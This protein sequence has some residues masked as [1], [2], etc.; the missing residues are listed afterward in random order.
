MKKQNPPTTGKR[1]LCLAIALVMVLGMLP[2]YALSAQADDGDASAPLE[3][4][5]H[6]QNTQNWDPLNLYVWGTQ[7]ANTSDWPGNP[8]TAN[9]NNDGWFDQ[10]M[11][12]DAGGEAGVIP[13]NGSGAQTQDIMLSEAGHYW[14]TINED[15]SASIL[16]YAPQGWVGQEPQVYP[17]TIYAQKPESWNALYAHIWGSVGSDTEW[18]GAAMEANNANADWFQIE[19]RFA[20][21]SEL[22]MVL[23]NNAGTQTADVKITA[24]GSHWITIND[25]DEG[26]KSVNLSQEAPEGWLEEAPVYPEITLHVENSQGWESMNLH[27]WGTQDSNTDWP[28][29]A[30]TADVYNPGWFETTVH[31]LEGATAGFIPNNNGAPQTVNIELSEAG[32]YWVTIGEPAEEGAHHSVQVATE[33]PETWFDANRKFYIP[34]TFPGNSWDPASNEM[35]YDP[36][37]GLY[38]FTFENVPAANYQYKIAVDGSWAE[39][40]GVDGEP[41]GSNYDVAVTE[42][43]DVTIYY[44]DKS[45]RSV[46]SLNYVFADISLVGTGIPEGT[47]L[48][49]NGLTGI[50]S[51]SVKLAAGTYA[52]IQ[53][54]T[55]DAVESFASFELAEDTLVTF[56]IDPITG[57]CYHDGCGQVENTDAIYY[58]SQELAYKAPYGA[59]ANGSD[60]TFH[61]DCGENIQWAKLALTGGDVL[62]MEAVDGGFAVT[63]SFAKIGE[64][65][66]YFVLSDGA[67]V[68]VYGD[69]DGYYG[70]GCVTDLTQVRPFGLV[71]YQDG[72][73]TPDWVKNAVM[74][75]IFPDRFFDGDPSNN[76]AQTWARGTVGY[77]F[78]EDWYTLPENPEM[79]GKDGYPENALAGDGN[80]SNEMYGGDLEGITQRIDYLKALGVNVIYLNPV[81]WSISNHR[82][83]AVDYGTIDPILGDLGDFQELVAVAEA[84]DM[85]IILDGVFN[86]VSDDSIYFD[87]Y[88]RFLGEE[89]GL[90]TVGAYP[91]WAYVYDYMADTGA[92]QATAEAAAKTYFTD[93]YGVTDFSYVEWF[94]V[95]N[96][97]MTD[98]NGNAVC[99]TIGDRAGKPV[100]VYEG[101]WGYDSMPVIKSTNGSE[102]QTGNWAEKIIY[103]E[104]ESS[105]TQ[106]WITEG[107]NGWRLDVANEVSDE[108]WQ[109][110]RDSVKALDS[111]AVIIGEIWDD[112]TKYILGDMYDS[113]M[114]YVFRNNVVRFAM[115]E[116]T[117]TTATLEMEKIRERYPEEA[118]YAMMN[119]V[120]SHDTTRILSFL[121]GIPDDR[122]GATMETAFPTYETTS[123]T[124]KARQYLVSLLQFTYAGAPT[125]YYG[126]ELGMVG[127]D[128]PDDRR[129]MEWGRGQQELVEWYAKLAAIRESYSA[130]RTGSVKPLDLGDDNLLAFIRADEETTIT[131]ITNNAEAAKTV[132]L[133]GSF[134][135]LLT[136]E[137]FDGTVPADNGVILV[138]P[139]DV[140]EIEVNYA[141]LAPAYDPAYDVEGTTESERPFPDVLEHHWFY[142]DVYAMYDAGIILG[143]DEGLFEPLRDVNRAEFAIMLYRTLGLTQTATE[144]IFTD[145]PE[146]A[147][148]YNE[149]TVLAEL[150]II[151]GVGGDAFAPFQPIM[152]QELVTMVYR[153]TEGAEPGEADLTIFTDATRIDE[154][155]LDSMAWAVDNGIIQGYDDGTVQPKGNTIRAEAATIVNRWL[156]L[157][158]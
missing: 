144:P 113:V 38:T 56:Y 67:S 55:E 105:I 35:T 85:H 143:T 126:D 148:F 149:V 9:P 39:N 58:H 114:N 22:G 68:V 17:V 90:D 153:A 117:A 157:L 20:Q 69:D 92:D 50:Y 136:G 112:A 46:T 91:Y 8:M 81:F 152:R 135:D 129:S 29:N 44:S 19:A 146:T 106:Y 82:Y 41:D 89:Y 119:L 140:V 7:D 96:R 21:G 11:H 33:A 54:I 150:G 27:V 66:Y 88:Y 2:G 154:Y 151:N 12:I 83:D 121:D 127:A 102:F 15:N 52:D 74:Y 142:E 3:I 36:E 10:T 79:V 147:W 31:I 40:Y 75:Q 141:D 62:D 71:V 70:Q 49:D 43:T 32:E 87:R 145:V 109:N 16:T 111:E 134:V 28:G 101:W 86:H 77:E 57:I 45:H 48:T 25:A 139:E 72:F 63:T 59:V 118:F 30:M 107:N 84:N 130:L 26:N 137:A 73:E 6:V 125:I 14:I 23:H 131:V 51:A 60:V 94:L 156:T 103:N 120:G 97:A 4:T 98:G 133:E 18:P 78:V 53:V 104:D 138:S 155:A 116:Y 13:N 108:T 61:I 64:Y 100:Y 124:A 37:L 158:A 42:T 128:D 132:E 99:D 110:F 47:K 122:S 93:T 95:E 123:D 115:D 80:W 34:G 76:Q 65:G 1:W 5:I 24:P